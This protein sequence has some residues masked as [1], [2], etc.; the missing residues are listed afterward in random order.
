MGAFRE[1][2]RVRTWLEYRGQYTVSGD[3]VYV[4]RIEIEAPLWRFP[5]YE[6]MEVVDEVWLVYGP[7][8]RAF[9]AKD[10]FGAG[11]HGNYPFIK[12][13]EIWLE[14]NT[15][16]EDRTALY[17]QESIDYFLMKSYNLDYPEAKIIADAYT[18]DYV[19]EE[20][21][22]G[23]RTMQSFYPKK[24]KKVIRYS[25]PIYNKSDKGKN[26]ELEDFRAA[27]ESLL[28]KA[29]EINSKDWSTILGQLQKYEADLEKLPI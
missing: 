28:K 24:R 10:W 19:A 3:K 23:R 2:I 1:R 29:P 21:A 17:F 27:K 22:T 6:E 12:P 11:H 4:K 9:L 18:T 7:A 16:E 5:L 13:S 20:Y 14:S 15:Y 26:I 8:I 25:P